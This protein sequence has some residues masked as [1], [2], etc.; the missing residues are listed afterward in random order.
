MDHQENKGNYQPDDWKGIEHAL[1]N[2]FQDQFSV[3][4]SRFSG[5]GSQ[6]RC[7]RSISLHEFVSKFQSFEKYSPG[8][9]E[10][11]RNLPL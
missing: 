1:E 11:L 2:G 10:T 9:F 3:L 8:G 7:W 4:R 6:L 5:L